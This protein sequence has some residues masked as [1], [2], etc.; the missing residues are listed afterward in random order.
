MQKYIVCRPR[1]WKVAV[2]KYHP[3]WW[4]DQQRGI[5][6]TSW[7]Q[8]E[9]HERLR[10]GAWQEADFL[11]MRIRRDVGWCRGVLNNFPWMFKNYDS[12]GASFNCNFPEPN[13]WKQHHQKKDVNTCMHKCQHIHDESGTQERTPWRPRHVEIPTRCFW[14]VLNL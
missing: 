10:H 5:N 7:F 1:N 3:K 11:A 8:G 12:L 4:F 14:H 2:W 9:D 6:K 13:F